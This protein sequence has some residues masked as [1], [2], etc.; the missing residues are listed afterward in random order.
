MTNISKIPL[1]QEQEQKLFEQL[2]TL[3]HNKGASLNNQIL[4]EL[5]GDE[6]KVMIAKRLAI[7]V[8]LY[9]KQSLYFIAQTLHVSPAT[10]SR[11]ATLMTVGRYKNICNEFSSRTTKVLNILEA[12]DSILHLGGILPHYGIPASTEGYREYQ[13]SKRNK[14]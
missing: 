5:L 12:I 8:L 9:R 10:V 6:E 11:V 13:K 1:D 4:A 7:I 2:G 14:I 3:F